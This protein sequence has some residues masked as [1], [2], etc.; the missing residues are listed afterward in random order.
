MNEYIERRRAAITQAMQ[1]AQQNVQA[2]VQAQAHW[3]AEVIAGSARLQELDELEAEMQGEAADDEGAEVGEEPGECP[4][5]DVDPG[6]S[7]A[8]AGAIPL[9][10]RR[11]R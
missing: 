7:S 11:R 2:A 1:E 6:E 3:Q 8:P 9:N 10:R 4:Q 5:P